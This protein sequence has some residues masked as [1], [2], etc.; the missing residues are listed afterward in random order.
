LLNIRLKSIAE[1]KNLSAQGYALLEDIVALMSINNKGAVVILENEKPIGIMTERDIV[2]ILYRGGGLNERADTFANK[3]LITA[4]SDRSLIHALNLMIENNVRRIVVNDRINNFVGLVTQKDLLKYL[5][6]DCY[7]STLKAKHVV[8]KMGH[9]I[10]ASP[11]DSLNE[12]LAQMVENKISSVAVVNEGVAEG[13]VSEQ[14]ILRLAVRKVSFHEEVKEYM[15]TPVVSAHIETPVIDIVTTMN[16]QNIRRVVVLDDEGT[17]IN[18]ITVRDIM[19]NLGG[20]YREFLER[21]LRNAKEILNLFPELLIEIFDIELEQF[22]SWAN[23][24]TTQTFGSEIVGMPVTDLIPKESWDQIYHSLRQNNKIENM[25]IKKENKI[26]EISGFCV[27]TEHYMEN[28]RIQLILKDITSDIQLSVIDPLTGIHNRRYINEYLEKEIERV[29]RLDSYFSLV[30]CDIDNFNETNGIYGHVNG[31]TVLKSLAQIIKGTV[32]TQ[33]SVGRYGG[34]EFALILPET[35]N[36]DASEIIDRLRMKIES[37]KIMLPQNIQL[38]ITASFGVATYPRDGD[39]ADD[40]LVKADERLH[41]A[42][43]LG[44]NMVVFI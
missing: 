31:D 44:K 8:K 43:K 16:T 24:K 14:D 2:D 18:I 20:D 21:K 26:Y 13:I 33:D 37:I 1:K 4:R 36:E 19:R 40:M 34:D 6:E 5:E 32:R 15:S 28:N 10:N 7:R 29:R 27:S 9:L 22:I 41:K 30:I 35:S 23:E 3:S 38:T 42:K 11:D 12:V 25:R 39:S 17:A